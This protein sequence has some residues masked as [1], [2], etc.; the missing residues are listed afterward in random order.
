MPDVYRVEKDGI[1][2]MVQ[3]HMLPYYV[4]NGYTVYRREYVLVTDTDAELERINS[5]M[6]QMAKG[7]QH[8]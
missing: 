7:G 8:G 5:Q 1:G 4:D 3:A 6:A 2:L